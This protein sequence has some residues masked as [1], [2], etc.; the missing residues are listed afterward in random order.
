MLKLNK[1]SLPKR[2]PNQINTCVNVNTNQTKVPYDH[3]EGNSSKQ[4][5][6]GSLNDGQGLIAN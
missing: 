6:C 3:F 5:Q 1:Q 2:N 4:L